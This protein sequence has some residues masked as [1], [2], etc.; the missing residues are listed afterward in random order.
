[1]SAYMGRSDGWPGL[2]PKG[3]TVDQAGE[4]GEED[5]RVFLLLRCNACGLW[6]V[7]VTKIP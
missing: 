1:M 3:R 7:V 5:L 4:R 2:A 6:V